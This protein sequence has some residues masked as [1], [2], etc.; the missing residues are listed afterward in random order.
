MGKLSNHFSILD[1]IL[2][3]VIRAGLF[4]GFMTTRAVGMHCYLL[5]VPSFFIEDNQRRIAVKWSIITLCQ[6]NISIV[7]LIFWRIYILGGKEGS[8][9]IPLLP[10][11]V[12]IY[13]VTRH[14]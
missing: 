13:S 9:S 11:P 2:Q 7:F 1:K 6:L 3:K 8:Q 12:K 14:Q 5:D 4:C 10:L